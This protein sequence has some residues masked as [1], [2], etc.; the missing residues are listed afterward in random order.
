MVLCIAAIAAVSFSQTNLNTPLNFKLYDISPNGQYLLGTD[1]VIGGPAGDSVYLFNISN[2]RMIGLFGGFIVRELIGSLRFMP[3]GDKIIYEVELLDTVSSTGSL[4]TATYTFDISSY[5]SVLDPQPPKKVL[6]DIA[7]TKIYPSPSN[8]SR[9]ISFEIPASKGVKI[10]IAN[11]QGCIVRVLYSDGGTVNEK[12]IWDG[13]NQ[14]GNA[15][16]SGQYVARIISGNAIEA[17]M[18]CITE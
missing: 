18:V 11:L 9:A 5:L 1:L 8:G 13:K 4:I 2:Q 12:V 6:T 15:V 16:P 17:K 14:Y 7:N 10:E 3:S